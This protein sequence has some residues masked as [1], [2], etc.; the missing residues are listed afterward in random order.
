M[1]VLHFTHCNNICVGGYTIMLVYV[2]CCVYLLGIMFLVSSVGFA[3]VVCTCK[4]QWQVASIQNTF[5][6]AN[7]TKLCCHI[8]VDG[9]I[10]L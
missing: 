4:G 10:C 9:C 1:A 7:S 3:Q 6:T 5:F 2:L 8:V